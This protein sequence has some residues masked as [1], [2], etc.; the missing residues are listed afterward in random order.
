MAAVA[1]DLVDF[2]V[3]CFAAMVAAIAV[4]TR[5]GASAKFMSALIIVCHDRFPHGIDR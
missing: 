1:G 2:L 4:V 3:G 5:D